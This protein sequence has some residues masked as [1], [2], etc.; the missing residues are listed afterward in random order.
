[1]VFM[2]NSVFWHIKS[3]SPL[4]FN[5]S[6]GGARHH[7]Q[8]RRISE[9]K[10]QRQSGS[11]QSFTLVPPNRRLIYNGLHDVISQMIEYFSIVTVHG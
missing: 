8:G 4:K 5:C 6:F 9:T 7:L 3:Y 1:V 10:D 11:K 2:K